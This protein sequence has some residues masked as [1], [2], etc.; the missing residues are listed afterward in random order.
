MHL[1]LYLWSPLPSTRRS[2][3][4]V[5]KARPPEICSLIREL[6]PARVP[7]PRV[8]PDFAHILLRPPRPLAR[9]VPHF[10]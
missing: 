7:H 4:P 5:L 8:A 3:P 1:M 9:A 6:P 2:L 10:S